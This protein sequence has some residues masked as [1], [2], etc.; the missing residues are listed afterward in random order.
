MANGDDKATLSSLM[1]ST[2][3]LEVNPEELELDI[4]IA[5]PGTFEPKMTDSS[6]GIEISEEDDGGVIV[7]FDPSE[8][9]MVDENDFYRNLAEE[10]GDSD[11][12]T[13]SNELL[14]EYE[15][16]RSSR[17]D[18]ED[19]YSKGLELLGY[20]YEDRTMPFR[21]A[22]GV[23]HPLL[24]E[25]AT[26]FQAQAFNEL[27]PPGGPV[28]TAV[29]G[30]L[31]RD[32]QAQS[33]RVKE[34]MNYY[35]TSVMED[36]TPEFDQMLFYLPL[37]G[38]TF[39]KVYFDETIDRAVSKFVP[40]EDLVVPY[41][42][43]DLDTCPNVTQVV[44]MALN[45]VRK[46]QV[47]G[48]YR[49]IQVLPSQG[50]E[51]TDIAQAME[52]IEGIQPNM[53]DYDCTLLE[54]HVDLDLPGFE[55]MGEDGEP[56]G[57]KIPYVVTISEDNGQVLSIRRNY[58]EEDELKRKIQYFVHYKFLPGFG[59][60]GLGL[61]H[62]IGGLSRTATAALRQLIDA[63][64]F[65]NLPAGFKARGM[66]IRDDDEPLQPGEF[67]DVDAPGGAIRDSLLPLPFK[68]PD[69]TLFNLL[70]FVVDAGRRF[71]TITDLKVGD[72]NQGAAVGTTVAMLEQGSRVMSAVHKRLHYA[73][74]K[75]FKMLSR[76]M[77]EYLPQ[78]YPFSVEGGDRT[79]M[80]SDFDNRVDVVPVSN[81]N[82]FSQAQRIALAQSQLQIAQQAPQMHDLYEAYRRVYEALGV[83]DIDKILLPQSS[84]EPEPKDPAQ[85]NIDA[86]SGTVL[87][88]FEGQDHDAHI[89]AHLT[90]GTSPMVA[91]NPMVAINLQ[92]HILEH[93][94]IKAQEQAAVQF[95]QQT[96][97]QPL[98]QEL[99]LELDAMVARIEAQEMQ[100]LK[101]LSAQISGQGQ[102]GPDPLVQLKQQELQLDAQRQQAELAMDQQELAMD[103]QRMQNKQQEF[104]QRLQSQERQTQARIQ[105]ALERELL[106]QQN[107]GG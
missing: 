12:A 83:R 42:A 16:N 94:K 100:N 103:Q 75:E 24:A 10:M 5:S 22:T 44:K 72:G 8:M 85:E 6:E 95:M 36:Y 65:S 55:E 28:R 13:I 107:Q 91:Q 17:S 101:K 61:I 82:V 46:R 87:K 98:N 15:A 50:E 97:G 1:D 66:R 93:V 27:L 47:T 99:E 58:N 3:N 43:T 21:G 102:E 52:K 104:Q 59:F 57:I 76:V 25:A 70:G 48:F 54:C 63:G 90:F 32:K 23:T 62:T 56:T 26:Q 34:F 84:E 7:D 38:S 105:A 30:E 37:A 14:S 11:L 4:E 96:G 74:R 18:W 88:A 92:K 45:D 51:A 64:T 41:T 68:G 29:M 71:A 89:I 31:T 73:M 77:S 20:T 9:M 106:K 67:R 78:E 35:I 39:K 80:A 81:P 69:Q 2:A 60:Y 33:E 40:A 86:L 79:I 49:D 53:I 19:S